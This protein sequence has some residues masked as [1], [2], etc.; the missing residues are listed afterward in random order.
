MQYI[1][2]CIQMHT[3]RIHHRQ[4]YVLQ[5]TPHPALWCP[6]NI[7]QEESAAAAAAASVCFSPGLMHNAG[8]NSWALRNV[9]NSHLSCVAYSQVFSRVV[10]AFC[11]TYTFRTLLVMR[12]LAM[13]YAGIIKSVQI[14][15]IYLGGAIESLP[16]R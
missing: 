6:T 15:I 5:C 9:W 11:T 3:Q 1:F 10:N 7:A 16:R 2:I 8:I 4:R 13:Q 12:Q 14:I